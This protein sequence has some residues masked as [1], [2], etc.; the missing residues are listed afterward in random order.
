MVEC[1]VEIHFET[2]DSTTYQVEIHFD[3]M[4]KF[5]NFLLDALVMSFA[6]YHV[7]M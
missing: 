1:Q 7:E 6:T 3:H 2:F 5:E 4:S